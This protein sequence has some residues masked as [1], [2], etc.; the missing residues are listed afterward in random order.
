[1]EAQLR[2]VTGKGNE[3]K[4][5]GRVNSEIEQRQLRSGHIKPLSNYRRWHGLSGA[6][7]RNEQNALEPLLP[8]SRL[9]LRQRRTFNVAMAALLTYSAER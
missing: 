4:T 2:M 3:R 5:D 8:L 1:M 7:R 6:G 9:I